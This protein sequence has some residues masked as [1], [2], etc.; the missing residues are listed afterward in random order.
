MPA[1]VVHRVIDLKG[2]EPIGSFEEHVLD[3]VGDPIFLR[4]LAAASGIKPKPGLV[5]DKAFKLIII[6]SKQPRNSKSFTGNSKTE[7]KS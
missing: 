6:K 5:F 2:I 4:P 3:D 1:E 7:V